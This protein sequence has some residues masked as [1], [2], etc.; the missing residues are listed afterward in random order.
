MGQKLIDETGNKYGF[1]TVIEKTQDK[2][3][4][5]AW[6]CKCDCGNTK[7]V[8][9]SDLR[10]GKIT[11]CGRG[12][13]LRHQRNGVFKDETGNQYGRLTVLYRSNTS[14]EGKVMWRCKCECGN[15]CDVR[16]TDLRKG[17]VL[18]CGCYKKEVSSD[19]QFK[20]ETGNTYGYLT[21]LSLVTK[22]P[23]AIWKC[24]CR[25]GNITNVKGTALR[26]GQ[27]KSCGCLLSW[28]EE[29][30]AQLLEQINISYSRQVTFNDLL[31]PK[32]NKLR[33]D[34][35]LLD[36]YNNII[37][38]IEYQ[39]QQHSYPIK[40]FGGQKGYEK[41]LVRD[42]LKKDYCITHDIPILYLDKNSNLQEELL[43]F[44]N[45]LTKEK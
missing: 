10:M 6:L 41:Q 5:T 43:Q 36:K 20:D 30:I 12:C 17:K 2:N 21:V 24:Q 19:Y 40:H 31:S 23:K 3:G 13:S 9:G 7:I 4:R 44:Y 22:S 42:K 18:S 34:F 1:L 27:I 26:S 14:N 29:E 32:G 8:R 37:G 45:S 11:S 25:C 38:L 35:G 39:G 16:G 15:E 33:Y 28:K